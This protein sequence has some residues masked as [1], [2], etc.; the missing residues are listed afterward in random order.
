M[1]PTRL[2]VSLALASSGAAFAAA[3]T[4]GA[5]VTDPQNE[6]VQERLSEVI[7]TPNMI[8]CFMSALRAGDMVNQGNYIALIDMEKCDSSKR[9][10]DNS[11]STS[12]GSSANVNYTRVTVNS[13]RTSNSDPQVGKVWF[14]MGMG[15]GQNMDMYALATVNESPSS[16][17]PNGRFS[18]S[19]CGVPAGTSPG[20]CTMQGT[21]D[22]SGTTISFTETG[23]NGGGT[24]GTQLALDRASDGTSGSGRI[25]TTDG[26]G[27]DGAFAFNTTHFKRGNV[28]GNACFS[29]DRANAEFSTWRYGVYNSNGS[30]LEAS[31][32]GFPIT[33]TYSNQTYWGYAGFWGVFLPSDVL[34]NVTQVQRMTPGSNA[35]TT[36][37]LTKAGGKLYRMTKAA[38]TLSALKGQ[39]VMVFLP[40]NVVSGDS[41]GGSTRWRG[42]APCCRASANRAHA[43]KAAV[44]GPI[45]PARRRASR[46]TACAPTHPGRK[47]CRAGHRGLAAR[48]ASRCPRAASLPTARPLPPAPAPWW[49][50]GPPVRRRR[51]PVSTAAPRAVCRRATSALAHRTRTSW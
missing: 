30:R 43:V 17:N 25:R 1:K 16:S 10:Q 38:G 18:I 44:R 4:S 15:G 45:S 11:S 21:L 24:Y 39:P 51:W 31:N 13:A 49:R 29:R 27:V 7:S 36:Y 33:A 6:W 42:M 28:N 14:T 5:Y 26:A 8:M 34:N 50:R 48:C 46:R 37:T 35:T 12:A 23:P 47:P 19:F 9:G 3:P 41:T 20:T 22:A 40:P 2:V 32:P